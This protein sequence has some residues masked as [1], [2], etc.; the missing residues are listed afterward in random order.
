V[1]ERA[2]IK[3]LDHLRG[4]TVKRIKAWFDSEAADQTIS[5]L[6]KIGTLAFIGSIIIGSIHHF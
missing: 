4:N 3:T 1:L 2:Y 5:N 6:M